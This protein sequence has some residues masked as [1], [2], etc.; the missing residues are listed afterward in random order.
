MGDAGRVGAPDGVEQE[1]AVIGEQAG[2]L[3]EESVVEA[4]TDMLEHADRDDAI[5]LARHVAVVLQTK[6][7]AVRDPLLRRPP[8]PQPN[9]PLRR[10]PARPVGTECVRT[11]NTT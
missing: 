3:L 1:H 6:I 4:D 10:S 9:L 2:D 8:A 5:E 7:D 11:C